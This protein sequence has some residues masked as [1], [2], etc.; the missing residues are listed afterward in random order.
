METGFIQGFIEFLVV[1]AT[2]WLL[3]IMG[4]AFFGAIIL[5]SLVYYTINRQEW[6][7]VEFQK[8]L[9]DFVESDQFKNKSSHSY[10]GTTKKLLEKTYYELFEV[11]SYMKRRKPD[12]IMS[13][14]DRIF[15]IQQGTAWFVRDILKQLKFL[16]YSESAHPKIFE[17]SRSTFQR[18]PCFNKVFGV[19][20]TSVVSDLLNLLPG[21]FIVMG[22]L[23]TFLGISQALP[24]LGAMDLSD[25]EGTKMVMDQ[26]LLK[27]SFSMGTSIM[28]IVLSFIMSLINTFLSPNKA[29][30]NAVERM[31]NSLYTIWN[32]CDNNKTNGIA[33]FDEHKDPVAALAEQAIDRQVNNGA[34]A[35]KAS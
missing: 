29:F 24:D 35:K 15:L 28:G 18:N 19:I 8:R 34:P 14:T 2:D 11:R 6:F 12:Y 5:R 17:I 16:P 31:E 23:G 3:P 9:D 21:L 33:D 30:I 1:F 13:F 27:I 32:I 20:P 7:A 26:F 4:V 25:M 22:I 10:Y